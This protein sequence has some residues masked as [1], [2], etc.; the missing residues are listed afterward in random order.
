MRKKVDPYKIYTVET[1][2]Q[3]EVFLACATVVR[4]TRTQYILAEPVP[5]F[6]VL[7]RARVLKEFAKAGRSPAE[8]VLICIRDNQA[9]IDW[10]RRRVDYLEGKHRQALALFLDLSEA[11]ATPTRNGAP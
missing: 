8:A 6:T 2:R 9:E 7:N 1:D 3:G 10:T 11:E 4:E 5:G